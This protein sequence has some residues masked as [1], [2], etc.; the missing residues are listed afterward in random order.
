ME[1][2]LEAQEKEKREIFD[3]FFQKD[4]QPRKDSNSTFLME[5]IK[6]QIS[7]DLGVP[8]HQIG[9]RHAKMWRDRGFEPVSFETW[10]REP[11]EVEKQRM[12]NMLGGA[13]LRKDL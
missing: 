2:A 1:R 9:T 12:R 4:H 13:S 8:W 11:N 7:K 6:D 10:Y 5:I 3:L